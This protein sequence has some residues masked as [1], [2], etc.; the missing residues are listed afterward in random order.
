MGCRHSARELDKS[1]MERSENGKGEVTI[2][3]ME[4]RRNWW[5]RI[6]SRTVPLLSEA[7]V[8]LLHLHASSCA[9]ERNWSAWGRTYTPLRNAL[10]KDT[11]E[12]MIFVKAN[13]A[14]PSGADMLQLY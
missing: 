5:R 4:R 1:L 9:A 12:K 11:A 3:S 7:A 8:R 6:A 14:A 13:T 2:S 10:S